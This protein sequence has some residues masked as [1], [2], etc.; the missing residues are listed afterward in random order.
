MLK[1][2]IADDDSIIRQGL[3]TIIE[4]RTSGFQIVGEAANGEDAL[5]VIIENEIDILITDIKMPIMDGVRLIK[6][7]R[8]LG[9]S[10][11]IIVLS[12]FDEYKF[13]RETLKNGAVDYLLKPIE[14]RVLIELLKKLEIIL[15]NEKKQAEELIILN[16]NLEKV[17][18]LLKNKF[19]QELIRG[20]Y[21][22]L[23]D[24]DMLKG[25]NMD[26]KG[27]FM[28]VNISI[29]DLYQFS[30]SES[31]M[32]QLDVLNT[33]HMINGSSIENDNQDLMVFVMIEGR[34]VIALFSSY[35]LSA[36]VFEQKVKSN[37]QLLKEQLEGKMVFTLS[38]GISLQFYDLYYSHIAYQQTIFS[39]QRRFYE[40]K[41]KLMYYESEN[42][43]YCNVM[44]RHFDDLFGIVLECMEINNAVKVR[45]IMSELLKEM[46]NIKLTPVVFR[47][48]VIR[49]IKQPVHLSRE[50]SDVW[51]DCSLKD[52]IDFFQY[53]LT[54][55]TYEE[56]ASYVPA[57]MYRVTERLRVVRSER[58]KKVVEIAKEYIQRHIAENISL[59]MVAS[60]VFLNQFYF[61]KIFKEETGKNFTEYIIKQRID[62]AKKLIGR[63]D[64]KIY[65]IG[66]M[67]GYDEPGSFS[68]I[69]KKMVGM[70]P[71]EYRKVIK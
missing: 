48:E 10:T 27:F 26:S 18:D 52:N 60:K 11:K 24:A 55:E 67:V 39:L 42:S 70:S 66:R 23:E 61:S 37:L 2:L 56:I 9:K 14:K 6:E 44:G 47:E 68:R 49:A 19:L 15:E 71:V 5:K 43:K 51:E 13:V 35:K 62:A 3:K 46:R 69:F 50:L 58:S 40:G 8:K 30:E 65:E 57:F 31:G 4:K 45:H 38:I 17:R 28:I 64:I 7:I 25:F 59:E 1:V 63:P 41:G 16:H 29:D 36:E 32:F 33:L 22:S 21:R 20:D 54:V 53:I 34:S 12:G